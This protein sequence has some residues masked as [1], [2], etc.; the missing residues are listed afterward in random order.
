[1]CASLGP[2]SLGLSELPGLSGS[3]FPLPDWGSSPSLFVQ[4]S[5]LF[6]FFERFYLFTFRE[7]GEGR[8]KER[9]RNIS[10]REILVASHKALNWGPGPLP[11]HVP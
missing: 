9:E 2:T 4:I 8:E 7:R 5:F 11:R 1:M 6:F 10:V 3:Q